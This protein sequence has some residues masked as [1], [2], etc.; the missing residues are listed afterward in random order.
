MTLATAGTGTAATKSSSIL[1]KL[2]THAD[3][4]ADVGRAARGVDGAAD[5]VKRLDKLNLEGVGE[6][7]LKQ[8]AGYREVG[9]AGRRLGE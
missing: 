7:F 8:E 6:G 1:A 5:E 9:K 4:F 2:G 3:D